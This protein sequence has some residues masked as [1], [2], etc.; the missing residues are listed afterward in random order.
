MPITPAPFNV[1]STDWTDYTP[2]AEC[3]R[4]AVREVLAAG[5]ANY[6]VRINQP[7]GSSSYQSMIGGEEFVFAPGYWLRPGD[8][9]AF[10]LKMATSASVNFDGNE[11]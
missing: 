6:L 7:S 4:I 10:S 2:R 5:T 9:V 8:G 3:R 11:Q 1:N